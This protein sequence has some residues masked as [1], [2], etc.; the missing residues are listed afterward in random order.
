MVEVA[1]EGDVA[2]EVWA[3]HEVREVLLVVDRVGEALLYCLE[4][5]VFELRS[6]DDIDD[7]SEASCYQQVLNHLTSEDVE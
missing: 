7:V 1:C 2:D 6:R 5:S 3:V 4:L